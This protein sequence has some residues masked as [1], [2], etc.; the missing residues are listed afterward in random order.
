MIYVSNKGM[1]AAYS[2]AVEEY[3]LN[4][5]TEGSLLMLWRSE[6]TVVV[7]KFQNAFAEVGVLELERRGIALVRRN[8]GGGTVYHDGGNLNFTFIDDRGEE[9][10][11]YERFLTP[12]VRALRGLGVPAELGEA[13]DITVGGKKVSGNAESVVRGR[14][15]HHG[16]L[17][18]DTE[19]DVLESVTG[20]A[21]ESVK[22]KAIASRPSSV[23][24]LRPYLRRDMDMAAFTEYMRAALC[25]GA[26]SVEEYEFTEEERR[27]IGRLCEEKYTSWEWSFGR[28]PRFTRECVTA[29]GTRFTIDVRGGVIESVEGEE[30]LCRALVGHRMS[31]R[32]LCSQV[33]NEIIEAILN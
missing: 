17:L 14:I 30:Y 25:G 9:S 8:S 1:S 28:S 7:G 27:E 4:N 16:T 3:L 32:D 31:S 33:P 18:F 6:P 19:L 20:H 29:D 2:L 21:R 10:P 22:T 5:V 11:E 12:V 15:M 24:N 13:F 23:C 26:S